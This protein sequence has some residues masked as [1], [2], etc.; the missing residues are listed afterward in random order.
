MW[1]AENSHC[2][3][4]PAA[5]RERWRMSTHTNARLSD[6]RAAALHSQGFIYGRTSA[7]AVWRSGNVLDTSSARGGVTRTVGCVVAAPRR[8][9][10]G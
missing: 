9:Q 8:L 1:R 2:L 6:S 7:C 5:P 10:P 3:L 4:F